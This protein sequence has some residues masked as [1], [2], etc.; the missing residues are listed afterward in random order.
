MPLTEESKRGIAL[1]QALIKIVQNFYPQAWGDTGSHDNWPVIA[2]AHIVRATRSLEAICLLRSTGFGADATTVLR[3]LFEHVVTFAWLAI[4]P[5]ANVP[6]WLKEDARAR[7]AANTA[8]ESM[9]EPM[10]DDADTAYF[11]ERIAG[12]TGGCPSVE[13]MA[14]EADAHW[15]TRIQHW[16]LTDPKNN[17]LGLYQLVYRF[18]SVYVHPRPVGLNIVLAAPME[19]VLVV[20]GEAGDLDE[21]VTWGPLVLL[22]G[23]LVGGPALGWPNEDRVLDAVKAN[24][25]DGV[26]G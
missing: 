21:P 2:A 9:D 24:P 16:D 5:A 8:L 11:R 12:T 14:R 3:S 17:F 25:L 10:F 20:G 6:L 1:S 13:G 22:L 15:A 19:G 7:I 23:L 26:A 18:S 4:D